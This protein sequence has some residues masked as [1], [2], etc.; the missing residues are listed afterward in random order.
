MLKIKSAY[1][2]DP[3]LLKTCVNWL[4]NS[5]YELIIPNAVFSKVPNG[6]QL[7]SCKNSDQNV[8]KNQSYETLYRL[9]I[10]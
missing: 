3:T 8:E 6:K 2:K 4:I 5:A 1:T 9:K 10:L 7:P